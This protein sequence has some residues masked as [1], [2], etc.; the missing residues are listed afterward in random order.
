MLLASHFSFGT[1][2]MGSSISMIGYEGG[3]TFDGFISL[4]RGNKTGTGLIRIYHV[5]RPDLKVQSQAATDLINQFGCVRKYLV[6]NGNDTV[7]SDDGS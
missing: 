4:K 5:V 6:Y 1:P 3:S 7:P 2:G